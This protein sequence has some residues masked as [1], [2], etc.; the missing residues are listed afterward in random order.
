[1]GLLTEDK[2]IGG[3]QNKDS[4]VDTFYWIGTPHDWNLLSSQLM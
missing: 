4:N 2:A 3:F 1:M